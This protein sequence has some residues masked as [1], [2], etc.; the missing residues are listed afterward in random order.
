MLVDVSPG[1]PQWVRFGIKD[2]FIELQGFR[3]REEQIKIFESLSQHE[4]LHF[5][6]L[7]FAGHVGKR[8][9]SGVRAA[10]FNKVIEHFLAHLPILRV[11]CVMI[12]IVSGLHD[13]GTQMITAHDWYGQ[14][15]LMTPV[16]ALDTRNFSKRAEIQFAHAQRAAAHHPP[17]VIWC[18]RPLRM[19]RREPPKTQLAQFGLA[20]GSDQLNN[21]LGGSK[22]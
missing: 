19:R 11:A 17:G 13:L 15:L 14:S 9:V 8:S 7:L 22:K 12:K 4:A 20:F 2:D 6:A 16:D 5:V 18:I 10:I 3:R 21:L 1:S